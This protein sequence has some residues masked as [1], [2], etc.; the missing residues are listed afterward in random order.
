MKKCILFCL[1]FFSFYGVYAQCSVVTAGNSVDNASG[2]V[3]YSVGQVAYVSV[4]N[5]KGSVSQGVQQTYQV[6]T[7]GI[8]VADADF[9]LSVFPNPTTNQLTLEVG[10]YANQA[11]T[12]VLFDAEGKQLQANKVLDKQTTIDMSSLPIATYLMEVYQ[13]NKQVQSFKILK[14]N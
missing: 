8:L 13:D 10:K 1:G 6:S 5:D 12:Y 11:L 2:S 7:A 9:S 14:V 3:S 4:A